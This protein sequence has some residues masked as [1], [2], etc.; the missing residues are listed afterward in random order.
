[1]K[2]VRTYKARSEFLANYIQFILDEGLSLSETRNYAKATARMYDKT[3]KEVYID[4]FEMI[5]EDQRKQGQQ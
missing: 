3:Y 5:V 2:Q 4:A 1:M